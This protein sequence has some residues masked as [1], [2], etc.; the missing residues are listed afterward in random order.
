VRLYDRRLRQS[1]AF[2]RLGEFWEKTLNL[3]GKETSVSPKA[4]V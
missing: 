3:K 2:L 1:P 4:I